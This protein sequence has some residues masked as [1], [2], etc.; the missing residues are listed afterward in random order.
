M[1]LREAP[2]GGNWDDYSTSGA[3]LAGGLQDPSTPFKANFKIPLTLPYLASIPGGGPSP[4]G[5]ATVLLG[6]G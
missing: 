4:W 2:L 5:S 1:L 6:P 3:Q